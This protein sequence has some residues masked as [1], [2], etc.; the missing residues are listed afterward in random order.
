MIEK[1]ENRA[2]PL[3]VSM[4][5]AMTNP[6]GGGTQTFGTSNKWTELDY[7]TIRKIDPVARLRHGLYERRGN[8]FDTLPGVNA[9]LVYRTRPGVNL[10][11][12]NIKVEGTGY[13]FVIPSLRWLYEEEKNYF[14]LIN[15][16]IKGAMEQQVNVAMFISELDK[17]ADLIASSSSKIAQAMANVRAG[18]FSRAARDLGIGT[19]P[20]V[21]RSRTFA[22]NW[23][24]YT[25][26]WTPIVQDMIGALRHVH[27]GARELLIKPR[28][29]L[30]WRMANPRDQRQAQLAAQAAREH[31]L[32]CTWDYVGTWDV[33]EQVSLVFRP[34]SWFWDQVS[35]TG[36]MDPGTLA[37]E[38][39]PGSFMLDWFTNLGDWLA[40]L[41]LG[42]TLE[43]VTGSYVELHRAT[44][45]LTGNARWGETKPSSYTYTKASAHV[46][47]VVSNEYRVRRT[48]IPEAHVQVSLVLDAPFSV[49]RA[50]TSASLVVQ[51]LTRNR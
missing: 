19:P 34:T 22:N 9:E 16:A 27:R 44:G 4:T 1:T 14:Q 37:Y 51:Q 43:Y 32:L 18:K 6:N 15:N 11:N 23:L 29:R 49:N 2:Y 48:P 21:R 46:E 28:S 3:G 7:R 17:T 50:I 33:K 10:R 13:G 47:R 31:L 42:L 25:Y 41:N 35:R 26:G 45:T 8:S 40:A 20:G 38:A 36:F 24:E 5:Y 30:D 39:I 12:F